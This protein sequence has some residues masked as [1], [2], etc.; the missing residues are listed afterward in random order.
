M[1]LASLRSDEGPEAGKFGAQTKETVVVRHT[2]KVLLNLAS[3]RAQK[4]SKEVRC[5]APPAADL[6]RDPLPSAPPNTVECPTPE[7]GAAASAVA[8]HNL[9]GGDAVALSGDKLDEV[10]GGFV[11]DAGLQVS[12][13]I[14]RAIYLNGNLVTTTSLNVTELGKVST[15]QVQLGTPSAGGVTLIQSGAGNTFLPGTISPSAVG[16]VIQNTLDNQKIQT[17]T[18]IDAAVTAAGAVRALNLQSS[19][20]GAITNSLRR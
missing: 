7:P 20:R 8:G 3:I 15:G 10:R 9:I 17:I 11:T 12:F 4:V 5:K 1:S 13:G 6:Q 16:T 18:R 2:D 14:E 19:L